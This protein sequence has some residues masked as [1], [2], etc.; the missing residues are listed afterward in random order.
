MLYTNMGRESCYQSPINLGVLNQIHR[1][2][3][4]ILDV[5]CGHGALGE[6]LKKVGRIVD[7]VTF[8]KAEVRF[9]APKYR[10]VFEF[11]LNRGLP[12]S[13]GK[14]GVFVLSHVLEHLAD[15]GPLMASIRTHAVAGAVVV[16]AVPNMLVWVNRI[17]LLRGRIEYVDCGILDFTHLRWYTLS[18]FRGL[19]EHFDMR[20]RD[21]FVIGHFPLGPMRKPL[22]AKAMSID[23][24][25]VDHFPALF[26]REF[27]VCADV[28]A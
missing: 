5:G 6:E 3:G 2:P 20:V 21:L 14:Y 10:Q 22:G 27:I 13:C 1:F 8:S 11:D 28:A 26:G 15:P 4:E 17:D 7:G 25:V 16:A 24:L 12:T 9:A 19:F 18:S 23:K